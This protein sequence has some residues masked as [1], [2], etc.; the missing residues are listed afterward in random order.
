MFC[1]K[2]A[3]QSDTNMLSNFNINFL[4]KIL[5]I[6][7]PSTESVFALSIDI[8]PIWVAFDVFFLFSA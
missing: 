2:A 4:K 7:F 8:M 5:N 3:G 6:F 1:S